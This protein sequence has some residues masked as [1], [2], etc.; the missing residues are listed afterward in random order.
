MKRRR[1]V[2]LAGGLLLILIAIVMAV[3]QVIEL[4]QP[5]TPITPTFGAV[6]DANNPLVEKRQILFMSNRDG[7]WDL[8][9][10]SLNDRS[11]INLTNNTADDGFGS[12]SA[13]GGAITFLSNRD[14]ILNPYMM[15]GDGSDQKPVAN[16]LPTIFSVV[17][18]GRL[19]WG[20]TYNSDHT[21]F[22][23]LRDLNLEV[24]SKDTD[25]E[26]N[27]TKNGAVDW[28]PSIAADEKQIAFGSDRDGNQEIYVMNADGSSPRRLTN[29]PGDDLYPMWMGLDN[30]VFMSDRD[31]PFA[32][33]QIGLYTLDISTADTRPQRVT[34]ATQIAR[35]GVQISLVDGSNLYGA[36]LTGHWDIYLSDSVGRFMQD[37]TEN[38][39]DNLLAIWRPQGS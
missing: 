19:N 38:N 25:G 15:N 16:D 27:L 33:G 13:D 8:Y 30:L 22:V 6:S 26:H 28:F 32:K 17:S 12:Y 4:Q 11:V 36:N 39:G 18:S 35:M 37:L 3:V 29:A 5:I 31:I 20:F 10:M 14:G 7:D 24:Y 34:T 23:S 9:Q 21:D 1:I 2:A